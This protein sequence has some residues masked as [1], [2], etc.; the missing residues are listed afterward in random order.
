[1]G[2]EDTEDTVDW[3]VLALGTMLDAANML[4]EYIDR[5]LNR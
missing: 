2:L 1:M 3:E 5:R 4:G